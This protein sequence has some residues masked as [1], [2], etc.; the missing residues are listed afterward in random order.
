MIYFIIPAKVN[1]NSHGDFTGVLISE[2]KR[3]YRVPLSLINSNFHIQKLF[4]S[5]SLT[6][7]A[8]FSCQYKISIFNSFCRF[9]NRRIEKRKIFYADHVLVDFIIFTRN[10]GQ[11]GYLFVDA[12]FEQAAGALIPF[13]NNALI[14]SCKSLISPTSC[15]LISVRRSPKLTFKLRLS[16]IQISKS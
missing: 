2:T 1:H 6:T 16:A 9:E 13:E 4:I 7:L 3:T 12:F 5:T 11:V 14:L 8:I 10:I 15:I